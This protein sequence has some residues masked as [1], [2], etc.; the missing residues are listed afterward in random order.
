MIKT[1]IVSLALTLVVECI[2]AMILKIRE[3]NGLKV[4][5]LANVITNPVV[6]FSSTLVW[7]F[8][9]PEVYAVVITAFEVVA[10][11]VET[12]IYKKYLFKDSLGQ[13]LKISLILNFCSYFA[14]E[15]INTIGF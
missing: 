4:V 8:L 14:G 15:I 6:V 1:L 2:G 11:I 10:I 12:G 5:A 13:A 9:G 3:K 7:H